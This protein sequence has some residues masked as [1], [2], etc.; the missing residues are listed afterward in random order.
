LLGCDGP[1]LH[2]AIVLVAKGNKAIIGLRRHINYLRTVQRSWNR[3]R[4]IH[5]YDGT[6]SRAGRRYGRNAHRLLQAQY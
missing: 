1:G 2:R 5:P 4:S 3:Q 6:I